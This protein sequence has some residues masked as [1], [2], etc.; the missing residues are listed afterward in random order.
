MLWRAGSRCCITSRPC[1]LSLMTWQVGARCAAVVCYL[2][3]AVCNQLVGGCAEAGMVPYCRPAHARLH[4][5]SCCAHAAPRAAP[6]QVDLLKLPIP[7]AAAMQPCAAA[8]SVPSQPLC[9]RPMT[10]D[11]LSPTL[12]LPAPAPLPL[13][14]RCS[15]GVPA[16]RL[17]R[18]F[19]SGRSSVH[20]LRPAGG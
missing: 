20:N 3:P 14:C 7:T 6:L 1:H 10:H 8:P 12:L 5:S 13:L 2:L 11:A 9:T 4:M 15:L 16:P 19:L 18:A 17:G